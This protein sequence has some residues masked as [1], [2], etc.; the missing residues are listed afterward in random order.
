MLSFSVHSFSVCSPFKQSPPPPLP[1]LQQLHGLGLGT[2]LVAC[3]PLDSLSRLPGGFGFLPLSSSALPAPGV[4]SAMNADSSS[5]SAASAGSSDSSTAAG[6]KKR[7]SAPGS[8]KGGAAKKAKPTVQPTSTPKAKAKNSGRWNKA[9]NELFSELS[10]LKGMVHNW[11]GLA[12]EWGRQLSTHD[13]VRP[14]TKDQIKWK[15]TQQDKTRKKQETPA[16]K[17][18]GSSSGGQEEAEAEDEEDEDVAMREL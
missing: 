3:A 6:S 10:Q 13:G 18:A 9:E 2:Q 15:W 12:A 4:A 7:K 5:G 16:A 8:S 11:E 17:A 1:P 14:K